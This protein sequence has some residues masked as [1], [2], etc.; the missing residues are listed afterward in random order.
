MAPTRILIVEDESIIA[1]DLQRQLQEMGYEP[2]DITGSG[3]GAIAAA[4][5]HR[6]HLVLMDVHLSGPL[7]GIDAAIAIRQ[8][9]SIPSI[10]LTAYA[11]DEVINRAK[12]AEPVGYVIKPFDEQSLRTTIEVGLHKDR[13][14]RRLRLQSAALNAAANAMV[15]TDPDGTIEWVNPAFTA[16]T[17][18]A[19]HEAVGRNPRDLVKSG[20]HDAAFYHEMWETLRAGLVWEGEIIN[21]RKDGTHYVEEQTITPVLDADGR[22]AHY[23]GVKRDL[24]EHKRMQQQFLQAQKME[25]VGRLAG[26]IAHDFNNLLTVINGTAELSLMDLPADATLRADLEQIR[27]AGD[28]A[29]RLT[30]Q[31]LAFSRRQVVAPEVVEVGAHVEAA[32]RMLQRLIG[33]DIHLVIACEPA[34]E[35]VLIDPGHLEQVLLNLVVNARDAMPGGGTLTVATRALVVDEAMA[36][37]HQGLSPGRYLELTVTDTGVGMTEDIRARIF[38]PFFTTKEPGKG[39]GLG[40]ATVAGIVGQCGGVILVDSTPGKGTRF[41]VLL[42]GVDE[43]RPAGMLRRTARQER[44]SETILLV[45]DEPALRQ[46]VTRMLE[47]AGYTVLAAGNAVE[48]QAHVDGHVGPIH[49]LLTDVILPGLD[50]PTLAR[51]LVAA[52]PGLRVLFTSGYTDDKRLQAGDSP[53]HFLAKPFTVAELTRKVRAALAPTVPAG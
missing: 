1:R 36:T 33:E 35:H 28:R 12:A 37:R 22:I 46:L 34:R 26:G 47:G 31:L 6:P 42:P 30:R 48:A 29:V 16:M 25:V 11:T 2:V 17:G 43:G 44:G 18:Y 24:T 38:E 20:Q 45:E 3:E 21:R 9:F 52:H 39:T 4:E 19:P 27:E 41:T 7:D 32:S 53:H 5:A 8:R 14:D 13:A 51:Q 49:L 15:I 50:G 10:F 23:I 40:L